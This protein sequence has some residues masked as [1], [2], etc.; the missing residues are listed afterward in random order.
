M[1]QN[2]TRS[3]RRLR[4][5]EEVAVA[6]LRLMD[7]GD[8]DGVDRVFAP[9]VLDHDPMPGAPEGIEGVRALFAAVVAGFDDVR[10]EVE[11]QARIDD[12]RVVTVWRMTGRHV[13]EFLGVPATGKP[14]DFK[15][16]DVVRVREGRIVEHH[17]VEQLLQAMQQVRG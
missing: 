11:Y 10:H 3:T 2:E 1:S 17:H 4:E 7:E 13:G 6:M 12:E 8:V 16:I 5:P 14:V 15:G 9:D